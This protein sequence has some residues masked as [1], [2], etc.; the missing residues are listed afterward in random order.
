MIEYN[1]KLIGNSPFFIALRQASLIINQVCKWGCLP[2]F[3]NGI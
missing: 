2:Q 3:Y 1:K